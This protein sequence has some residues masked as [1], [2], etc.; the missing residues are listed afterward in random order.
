MTARKSAAGPY[1]AEDPEVPSV[2]GALDFGSLWVPMPARAQ[3]Q[4]EQGT[5]ELLRAVHV[6]VPSGRVSLSALAAPRS[7]P[8]W[9]ELADEIAGSLSGD[10]ARV[11]S[12]WGEWGR[13]VQAGS[14]GALSRFIGVDG[15][16]WMLYGVATGP[17]DG[18]AELAHTLREMMRETVVNRGTDPLPVKTVLPLRLPDHLEEM[19]EEAREHTPLPADVGD[20]TS[21]YD[22]EVDAGPLQPPHRRFDD[23]ESSSSA[24]WADPTRDDRAAERSIGIRRAELRPVTRQPSHPPEHRPA[25]ARAALPPVSHLDSMDTDGFPAVSINETT[26]TM[27]TPVVSSAEV[28][29]QPAWAELEDAPSF[30]PR[31][32]LPGALADGAGSQYRSD[33]LGM[34]PGQP[35]PSLPQS[36]GRED[37]D[38]LG[39]G[40]PPSGP[41]PLPGEPGGPPLGPAHAW[42]ARDWRH[43]DPRY[44]GP[45]EPP[46]SQVPAAPPSQVSPR[47]AQ[48]GSR[49]SLHDALT[50]DAA[51][52]QDRLPKVVV[53]RA[54]HRRPD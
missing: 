5:G 7:G 50:S 2:D 44:A 45:A 43:P 33:Q 13:E 53:R 27:A 38:D 52:T 32:Y 51:V 41:E 28:G 26:W 14:N 6:L 35:E 3:L 18:A 54:K 49:D 23:R 10:G 1:D 42:P 31:P 22:D 8:L 15:P 17:A 9:R 21:G 34:S 12:E 24:P 19:V 16:R 30:W 25:A 11:R 36:Q 20:P 48:S 4:V 37:L 40:L 47:S 46:R 39:F 29:H